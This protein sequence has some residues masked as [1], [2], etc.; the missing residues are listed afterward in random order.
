MNLLYLCAFV[1]FPVTDGDHVRAEFTLR[2]LAARHR[3]YG[4]FLDP[5]GV[6]IPGELKKLCA[7]AVRVPVPAGAIAYGA[8][9]ALLAGR[10]VHAHAYFS[11]IAAGRLEAAVRRWP[12]EAAHVH[13]IR[14]MPYAEKLRLPYVLDATDCLGHYFKSSSIL[15]GVRRI[16]ASLDGLAVARMERKWANSSAATLVTTRLEE[17]RME[18]QGVSGSRLR[19]VPNGLDLEY[20]SPG[21][22]R[23]RGREL[24]FL[25]NLGYPPNEKGL[26]WFL[27]EIAFMVARRRPGLRLNVIGQGATRSLRRAADS[28]PMQVAFSGFERDPRPAL[29]RAL[30]L[31][32]PLPLASGMQNKA[33]Q[34][35]ACGAPLVST[36]NVAKAL[37]AKPGKELLAG[38]KAAEFADCVVRLIDEPKLAGEIAK[39]GRRFALRRFGFAA[40]AARLY[41]AW[42]KRAS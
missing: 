10:S 37:G 25:G 42:G 5:D 12:L 35:M 13:R 22:F 32:C 40:A 16:Y 30:A 39:A 11:K 36:R 26:E 41:A 3:I 33:V 29:R 9:K 34:G 19:V 6:G 31:I 38:D 14:M 1:P 27:R 23:N 4:F 21:K 24:V 20:W 18:A 7:D 2:A 28:C 15:G 8:L 17:K